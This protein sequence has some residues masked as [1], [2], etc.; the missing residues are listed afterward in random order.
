[1][2]NSE[3]IF[4]DGHCGVCHWSVRFVA[5]H[6]PDGKTFRFAPLRG[7]VF[8][9]VLS[10]AQQKE[11]PDSLVVHTDQGRLLFRSQGTIY[12]LRRLGGFW[13]LLGGLLWLVPRP[14]R[15]FG[16][17]TIAR[18]RHRLAKPPAGMCPLLPPELAQRFDP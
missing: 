2:K 10:E 6:D 12:I 1:M 8:S 3:R 18:M 7:E 13:R 17:E 9:Q 11:L 4:Y 15:D 5:R 16:Y 14:L